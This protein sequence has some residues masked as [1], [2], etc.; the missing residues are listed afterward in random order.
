MAD[1][2]FTEDD[3]RAGLDDMGIAADAP[4]RQLLDAYG[5]LAVKYRPGRD[6]SMG[7]GLAAGLGYGAAAALGA[8]GTGNPQAGLSFVQPSIQAYN[9]DLQ[10][11]VDAYKN[12]PM[13]YF[14]TAMGVGK[15]YA[16]QKVE[17]QQKAADMIMR[18]RVL[19]EDVPDEVYAAA[20]KT[21]PPRTAAAA[22][23][24]GR[25]FGQGAQPPAPAAAAPNM[26]GT[27][28]AVPGVVTGDAPAPIG[29]AQHANKPKFDATQAPYSLEQIEG[30]RQKYLRANAVLGPKEA[31]AYQKDLDN[32]L[33]TNKY[34]TEQMSQ[35]QAQDPD[36]QRAIKAAEAE[37]TAAGKQTG[38]I[39]AQKKEID[40]VAPGIASNLQR[41]VDI[42]NSPKFAD[43]A[44]G[45]YDN[46]Q[47]PFGL[48]SIGGAR[49]FVTGNYQKHKDTRD[50]ITTEIS[51]IASTMK[52]FVRKAGEG[53]WT[54]KDQEY[55]EKLASG[56]ILNANDAPG[57]RDRVVELRDRINRTFLTKYGKTLPE[58]TGVEDAKG[59]PERPKVGVTTGAP[60]KETATLTPIPQDRA[61]GIAQKLTAASP[62]QRA[63]MIEEL[64]QKGYDVTS[65][66]G[67]R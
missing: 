59:S 58:L 44:V 49:A 2:P 62:E 19:G 56:E 1:S 53:V 30:A 12:A 66:L 25:I 14:G 37:G 17:R 57:L 36:Q 51:A 39:A 34:Y 61:A 22:P 4:H 5:K 26:A 32:M 65:I 6:Y 24:T 8:Y 64:K 15:Q 31:E 63:A 27:P 60:G 38:E 54:D 13:S 47:A 50:A 40:L 45:A 46:A 42:T 55:L 67:A 43:S 9:K 23:V 16:D 48:G 28:T 35:R 29:A 41:L 11:A 18:A 7:E 33:A 3:I 20:G 10:G 52:P 21:P